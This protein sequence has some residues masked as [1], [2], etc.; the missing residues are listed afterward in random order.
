MQSLLRLNLFR[1]KTNS[2]YPLSRSSLRRIAS[3]PS[4]HMYKYSWVDKRSRKSLP[5]CQNCGKEVQ[6]DAS[7]CPSCGQSLKGASTQRVATSPTTSAVLLEHKS[8]GIAAVLALILGIVGLWG[9]GHIYVGRLGR[10]IVL[11]I[12]GII[13]A[14]LTY[15]SIFLGFITLGLGFIGAIFFGVITFGVWIWQIFDAYSLAKRFNAAVQQ[16]GQ[17]PW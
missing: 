17:A 15:G 7:F 6:S 4:S 16:T 10:G 3:Q 11:L 8:P 2:S 12:V 13:L 5:F 14:V 1:G 9:I